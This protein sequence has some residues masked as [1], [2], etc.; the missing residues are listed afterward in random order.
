[1]NQHH[2]A[3]TS[4]S[5]LFVLTGDEGFIE[6]LLHNMGQDPHSFKRIDFC[7]KFEHEKL[8]DTFKQKSHLP[9]DEWLES[10]SSH[11]DILSELSL[12]D[13][14]PSDDCFLLEATSASK[15]KAELEDEQDAKLDELSNQ[16]GVKRSVSIKDA[17]GILVK[18]VKDAE[19]RKLI[20]KDL[21]SALWSCGK[22]AFHNIIF[23]LGV[24]GTMLNVIVKLD[25]TQIPDMVKGF[26][27][28]FIMELQYVA[29]V[30]KLGLVILKIIKRF[31]LI[32]YYGIK[33]MLGKGKVPD[34]HK[35][36]ME[37]SCELVMKLSKGDSAEEVLKEAAQLAQKAPYRSGPNPD[38]SMEEPFPRQPVPPYVQPS[39][40]PYVQQPM[41]QYPQQPT[42]YKQ[43]N[44][45]PQIQ[46]PVRNTPQ[47]LPQQ[48]PQQPMQQNPMQQN[49]MQQNPMQQNLMRPNPMRPNPMRPNPMQ[50]NLM[51]QNLMQQN[52]MQPLQRTVQSQ[53]MTTQFQPSGPM[54]QGPYTQPTY[55]KWNQVDYGQFDHGQPN[56]P[57]AYHPYWVDRY[58]PNGR[59]SSAYGEGYRYKEPA[60][61][62]GDDD[63]YMEQNPRYSNNSD[64]RGRCS[65]S[66]CDRRCSE[67]LFGGIRLV[68]MSIT[69]SKKT[70][71]TQSTHHSQDNTQLT[72]DGQLIDNEKST[73]SSQLIEDT[74][75]KWG[76]GHGSHHPRYHYYDPYQTRPFERYPH[77][78]H[79]AGPIH[80][81]EVDCRNHVA[82]CA[83]LGLLNPLH[84]LFRG[85]H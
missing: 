5:L 8:H 4:L 13:N 32:I 1:M 55:P 14:S 36:S 57:N 58:P 44:F 20:M 68:S 42:Q 84:Y 27:E 79:Y 43:Q 73:D 81:G 23:G 74:A 64:Y 66:C 40:P 69:G 45:Q 37:K 59:A 26:I 35:K 77:M 48:Y 25:F 72:D 15:S 29:E 83:L 75:G 41:Q 85:Y 6:L 21:T 18:I 50:Q 39:A 3:C 16:L 38:D 51:Q 82:G 17:A 49:P 60:F 33:D 7:D 67:N 24:I 28:Y 47:Q 12:E 56:Y 76:G 10:I 19:L 46:P 31:S 65:N 63:R 11:S 2:S 70:R 9:F 61:R 80:P 71:P 53:P 22:K 52:P 62:D 54:T 30:G 78:T 34:E